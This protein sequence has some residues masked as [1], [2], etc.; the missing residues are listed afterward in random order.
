MFP[1]RY[2]TLKV[3][4]RCP[5]IWGYLC[6]WLI[7]T[8]KTQFWGLS[9]F[10]HTRQYRGCIQFWIY[11]LNSLNGN[12]RSM[13]TV[14]HFWAS[15][16]KHRFSHRNFAPAS[17]R[18]FSERT[19]TGPLRNF[20]SS[21]LLRKTQVS[22]RNFALAYYRKLQ[23]NERNFSLVATKGKLEFRERNFAPSWYWT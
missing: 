4:K 14:A 20:R 9:R 21:S 17:I 13:D 15:L 5:Q 23:F 19:C 10:G 2:Y 16:L 18:N 8:C 6:E 22:E 7:V 3:V 12:F 11:P 1:I